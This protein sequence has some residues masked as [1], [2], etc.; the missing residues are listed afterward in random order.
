MMLC[1]PAHFIRTLWRVGEYTQ[2]NSELG[3]CICELLTHE[4]SDAM[5]V[6]PL[7]CDL[8]LI[9]QALELDRGLQLS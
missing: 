9:S 6:Q 7:S 8:R 5:E 4:A 2:S 1:L 3:T